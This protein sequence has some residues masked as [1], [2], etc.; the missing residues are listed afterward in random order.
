[1]AERRKRGGEGTA[2]T[3]DGDEASKLVRRVLKRNGLDATRALAVL[4]QTLANRHVDCELRKLGKRPAWTPGNE[5][6]NALIA[7]MDALHQAG[8]TRASF[9][10][11]Q[12][13]NP[14]EARETAELAALMQLLTEF[15]FAAEKGTGLDK[16][17]DEPPVMRLVTD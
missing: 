6:L 10:G 14:Q 9:G 12:F 7:T 8:G 17:D 2:G 4:A 3:D 15:Q 11:A 16:D 1:M 13:S 5:R